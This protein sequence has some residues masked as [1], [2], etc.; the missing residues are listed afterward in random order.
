MCLIWQVIYYEQHKKSDVKEGDSPSETSSLL[1]HESS[2]SNRSTKD[3]RKVQLFNF[4]SAL[5]IVLVTLV[6]CYTYIKSHGKHNENNLE[7]ED[8]H[9]QFL[10]QLMGW[11]SAIFYIGSRIPQIMKNWKHKSTEGLSLG[12][13]LCA[14]M[15]NIFFTMVSVICFVT[16]FNVYLVHIFKINKHELHLDESFMDCWKLWNSCL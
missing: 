2:S 1:N 6:S 12:M 8:E 14:V 11:T 7:E 10:P 16:S 4:I 13:F 3:S 9:L 5:S 15:G